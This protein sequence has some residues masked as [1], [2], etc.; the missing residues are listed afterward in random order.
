ML[1]NARHTRLMA[2]KK[3]ANMAKASDPQ[4]FAE[5]IFPKV[6]GDAAQ[7]SYMESQETYT[8]LF[9]DQR[10]YNAIMSALAEVIY[11]EMRKK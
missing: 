9:E 11:R 4:I 2:N 10:K 1:L 7:D 8:T 3:L 5:S 6:F